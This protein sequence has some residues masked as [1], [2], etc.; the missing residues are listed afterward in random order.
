MYNEHLKVVINGHVGTI[1]KV[2][3]SSNSVHSDFRVEEIRGFQ[4]PFIKTLSPKLSTSMFNPVMYGV[5]YKR[6]DVID[7]FSKSSKVN[8]SICLQSINFKNELKEKLIARPDDGE[9]SLPLLLVC[10]NRDI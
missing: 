1:S 4:D 3:F 5:L 7:F 8:M 2:F 6:I 9:H 10:I